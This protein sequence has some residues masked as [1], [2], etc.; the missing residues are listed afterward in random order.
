MLSGSDAIL[1]F[2]ADF[3]LKFSVLSG[4]G[5]SGVFIVYDDTVLF[6]ALVTIE[7]SYVLRQPNTITL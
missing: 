2:P 6:I 1:D 5:R 4:R 3:Y 7:V